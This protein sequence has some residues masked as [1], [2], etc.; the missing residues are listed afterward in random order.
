[1]GITTGEVA[2]QLGVPLWC[3]RRL[4]ERGILRERSRAGHMR[5][6]RQSDVPRIKKALARAGYLP[7]RQTS[8]V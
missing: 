7:A 1:M 3:V 6:V 8:A 2:K 4:F 5:L